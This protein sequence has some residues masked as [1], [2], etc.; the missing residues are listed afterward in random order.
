VNGDD[1]DYPPTEQLELLYGQVRAGLDR[2]DVE[3]QKIRE[4]ATTLV[5]SSFVVL[6]LVVAAFAQGPNPIRSPILRT[7]Y[8]LAVVLLGVSLVFG[9]RVALS[10]DL[11]QSPEPDALYREYYGLPPNL[12]MADLTASAAEA[13]RANRETRIIPRRSLLVAFQFVTVILAALSLIMGILLYEVRF[14]S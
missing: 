4:R 1:P 10:R 7:S 9:A 6:G 11:L 13:G 14:G 5:A 3:A 12:M 2:Q 8:A